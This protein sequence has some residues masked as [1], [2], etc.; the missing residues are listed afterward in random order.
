MKVKSLFI[1]LMGLAC[2]SEAYAASQYTTNNTNYKN[3][4]VSGEA[5]ISIPLFSTDDS[6]N[7]GDTKPKVRVPFG[8]E[9]GYRF[10]DKFRVGFNMSYRSHNINQDTELDAQDAKDGKD[11]KD[12]AN[13]SQKFSNALFMLNGKYSV[14]EFYGVKPYIMA[15]IGMNYAKNRAYIRKDTAEDGSI[16]SYKQAGKNQVKFAW[17]VGVGV[18]KELGNNFV[19]CLGYR[20]VDLGKRET[21]NEVTVFGQAGKIDKYD[22]AAP[23]SASLKAHEIILGITYNF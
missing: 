23:I 19:L 10:S 5:G 1:A 15:G 20:F 17:N 8:V 22:N 2:F 13:V 14:G 12:K 21:G 6:N 4:Y 18:E 11:I 9:A 7:Y 16:V 3:L